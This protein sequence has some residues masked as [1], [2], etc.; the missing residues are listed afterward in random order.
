MKWL[1]IDI[2]AAIMGLSVLAFIGWYAFDWNFVDPFFVTLTFIA[3][4]FF[5]VMGMFHPDP[6]PDIS[7]DDHIDFSPA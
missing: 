1:M 6:V 5:I 7:T 2:G 4:P 3:G